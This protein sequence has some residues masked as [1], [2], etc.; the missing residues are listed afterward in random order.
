LAEAYLD[1]YNYYYSDYSNKLY[2][3]RQAYFKCEE[4]LKLGYDMSEII[5]KVGRI[6]YY[7][8]FKARS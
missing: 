6:Y 4:A 1:F 3:K 7:L 2:Y 5:D 8:N